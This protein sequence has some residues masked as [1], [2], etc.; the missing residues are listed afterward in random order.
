[1]VWNRD[2]LFRTTGIRAMQMG[3][4]AKCR[5][6]WSG[7]SGEV[8][9]LLEAHALIMRGELRRRFL[10]V[11]MGDVRVEGQDLRFRSAGDEFALDLGADRAER[12]A[13][14]IA[15]PPPSLAKKLGVAPA[16]KVLVI[17]P[18]EGAVLAEALK[19][20]IAANNKEARLSLAVV[21]GAPALQHALHVHEALPLGTPIWIV[22]GKG[23]NA[24]FGEGP[25]RKLMRDAGYKDNKVS[26]VSETLSAT[27]YAR[28]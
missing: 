1:L 24:S 23:P 27:R 12:W 13:K 28:G 15:A 5:C 17:G 21:D 10:I 26:A 18:L 3:L 25:V 16:S 6:R 2:T 19:G 4:E 22:H 11:E 14:K 8:R 20:G 7:G 9:V